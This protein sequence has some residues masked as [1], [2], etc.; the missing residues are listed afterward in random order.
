MG[1]TSN[2]SDGINYYYSSNNINYQNTTIH[3]IT[4]T[5]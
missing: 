1:D 2:D 4:E 3:R 5:Q